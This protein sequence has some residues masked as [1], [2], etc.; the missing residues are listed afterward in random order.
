M[1]TNVAPAFIDVYSINDADD[2][3]PDSLY[4]ATANTT[5][6]LHSGLIDAIGSVPLDFLFTD[7][8]MQHDVYN[9]CNTDNDVIAVAYIGHA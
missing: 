9:V 2:S 8:D 4:Y 1:T 6:E 3:D 7:D 5:D